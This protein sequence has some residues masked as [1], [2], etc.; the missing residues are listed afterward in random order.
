MKKPMENRNKSTFIILLSALLLSVLFTGCAKSGGGPESGT[1]ADGA[2]AEAEVYYSVHETVI[3]DPD[4]AMSG[5]MEE[6]DWLR[7]VDMT[8]V[9]DTV[10]RVTNRWTE[11]EKISME[12]SRPY[13]QILKPPYTQW[14]SISLPASYWDETLDDEITVSGIAQVLGA[15][16]GQ[17]FLEVHHMG[18]TYLGIWEEGEK[19]RLLREMEEGTSFFFAADQTEYCYQEKRD[20][21]DRIVLDQEPEKKKVNGQIYGFFQDMEDGGV[22]WYGVSQGRLGIWNVDSGAAKGTWEADTGDFTFQQQNHIMAPDGAG[23]I[24]LADRYTLSLSNGGEAPVTLFDFNARGYNLDD[25]LDLEFSGDDGLL[26]LT[27]LEGRLYLL[28]LE[29]SIRPQNL[30]ELI[31]AVTL[32]PRSSLSMLI[33]RFNRQNDGRYHVTV[34]TPG[35]EETV[36][37]FVMKV[38][39]ELSSG[40]GPD[41]FYKDV[42]N[43]ADLAR[44]GYLQSLEGILK[45][46]GDYWPAAMETGKIDGVLYGMP[47]ECRLWLTAY[48]GKL[49]GDHQSLTLPEMMEAVQN[50]DVKMLHIGFGMTDIVT[51]YGLSDNDNK[52]FIDWEAGE[53]HLDEEPFVELLKFAKMYADTGQYSREELTEMMKNGEIAAENEGRFGLNGISSM[54]YLEAC[55]DGSSSVIGYPRSQGNGIYVDASCF[56]LS[57]NSDKREAAEAFFQF[58]L[59]EES[60][61]FLSSDQELRGGDEFVAFNSYFPVRLDTIERMIRT[62]QAE[63][64]GEEMDE[65][66]GI[67]YQRQGMSEEAAVQIRFLVEHALPCNWNVYQILGIVREEL[68][69]YAQGKRSAEETARILDNRVQTYLDEHR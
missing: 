27:K 7:E 2:Q 40:R 14:E 56:Y 10:Y 20:T 45:D 36:S 49:I 33:D 46:E 63:K 8:V 62:K 43:P 21:Y 58:L 9:G 30:Q 44:N 1:P 12:V 53:S 61:E 69:P 18:E 39:L 68:E 13:L 3:P 17:V 24:Y 28:A 42:F 11:L 5:Q 66:Y 60:Q 22:Y 59:S 54:N 37:E 32:F 34:Q 31:L 41:L 50:S 38:Q 47:C 57:A 67:L 29:P 51:Y 35:K 64:K 48:D 4:L 16:D 55:F 23:G 52:T 26:A 65:S 15:K 6:G 19:G 25:F